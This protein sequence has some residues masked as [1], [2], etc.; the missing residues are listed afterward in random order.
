MIRE[1]LLGRRGCDVFIVGF[2]IGVYRV[3]EGGCGVG[4]GGVASV[5]GKVGLK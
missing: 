2:D 1:K 5:M 3:G 4:R